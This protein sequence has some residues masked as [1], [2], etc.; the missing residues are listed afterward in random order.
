MSDGNGNPLLALL[1]PGQQHESTVAEQLIGGVRV[2][3]TPG[4]GRP[5]SR[6]RQVVADRSYDA[7]EFRRYLSGRGIR[8]VIPEKRLPEGKKRRRRGRPPVFCAVT[9]RGRNIIERLVGWLKEH[10][11]VATRFEKLARNFLAMVKLAFIR[12]YFRTLTYVWSENTL[13]VPA[14]NSLNVPES[15]N[16][17]K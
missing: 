8:G 15:S 3:T 13:I 11:R 16:M 12:R 1:T 10:R 5:R 17:A 6:P 2:K 9:Y 4:Q 7:T 14:N